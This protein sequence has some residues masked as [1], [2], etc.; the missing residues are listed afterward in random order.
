MLRTLRNTPCPSITFSHISLAEASHMA[1]P[2]VNAAGMA[3]MPLYSEVTWQGGTRV[4]EALGARILC[5]RCMHVKY[6]SNSVQDG[7]NVFLKS[8][9]WEP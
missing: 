5:T 3:A 8:L 7:K 1:T 4:S 6:L 2:R 9:L